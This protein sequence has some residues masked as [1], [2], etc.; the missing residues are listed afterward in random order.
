MKPPKKNP[1]GSCPYRKDVPSGVWHLS[2]YLKLITFDRPTAEQPPAV[3]NCHQ[4]DDTLC[5]GWVGC[6]PMEDS[7][8]LKIALV[9]G[10]IT[11]DD[12]QTCVDYVSPAPLFDTGTDAAVHGMRNL[13]DPDE[14]AHRVMDKLKKKRGIS[15]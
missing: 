7:L 14:Q 10:F 2:E 12:F 1:C 15:A 5:S 13:N 6:H 4:Q 9:S 3:F 11:P 8:G